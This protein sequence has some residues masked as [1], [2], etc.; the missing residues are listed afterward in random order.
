[1]LGNQFAKSDNLK[2]KGVPGTHA[3]GNLPIQGGNIQNFSFKNL[4]IASDHA[5]ESVSYLVFSLW[6][7]IIFSKPV[8]NLSVSMFPRLLN[9]TVVTSAVR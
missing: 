6:S 8:Q 1:M 5:V 3:I 4:L 7:S 2:A 9:N